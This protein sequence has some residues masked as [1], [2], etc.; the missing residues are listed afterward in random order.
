[1][2]GHFVLAQAAQT[3]SGAGLQFDWNIPVGTAVLVIGQFVA[4]IIAV[5][6]V[7]AK[8]ERSIEARFTEITLQLN[9]FKQGDLRDLQ[10]RLSRLETGADEWTKSLRLRTHEHTNE[11][12]EIKLKIDRL[13]RPSHY[14]R[15]DEG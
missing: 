14:P 6:R 1:M 10:S 2:T 8:V 9:T 3:V 15:K 4:G 13:E 5:M 7:V 12:N 11:I